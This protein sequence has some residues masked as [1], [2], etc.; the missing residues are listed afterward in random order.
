MPPK[1]SKTTHPAKPPPKN[2]SSLRLVLVESPSKC[3][4]IETYLGEGYRVLATYGHF[5]ELQSLRDIVISKD[6][7]N[8]E[9]KFQI[10]DR[11]E[12][13]IS[14]LQKAIT[15]SMEVILATDDDREGEA[16]AWHI[17]DHFH[18]PVENTK[19]IVFHEITEEAIQTAIQEPR[20]VNMNLVHAQFAR[21]ILDMYIGYKISP[22]LWTY[23][24]NNTK[25][26]LSAG[27]CQTPALKMIADNQ[28]HIHSLQNSIHHS[29]SGNFTNLNIPFKLNKYFTE[30]SEVLEFMESCKHFPFSLSRLE[31]TFSTHSAPTPL[32]TSRLQQQISNELHISP[33]ETMSI[34]QKL[35][36][37]G[38]ITYMRTDNKK[39]SNSFIS[40]V[41]KYMTHNMNES[42]LSEDINRLT[43]T[44][45]SAH[46]AIRPT[47]IQV[48]SLSQQRHEP[49]V[50]KVYRIIWETSV[51]SCL[52]S[53]TS[54]LQKFHLTAPNGHMFVCETE[55]P[56]YDGWKVIYSRK[57]KSKDEG[58]KNKYHHYLQNVADG[59]RVSCLKIESSIE[60]SS[61]KG[62][63]HY[64]E[65]NLIQRLEKEGIGR[66][67]TFAS[68]IDK[69]QR[70]DYA[71]KEDI[72]GTSF[73]ANTYRYNPTSGKI[74]SETITKIFGK[75]RNKLIIQNMGL[76]VN[77]FLYSHFLPLFDFSYTRETECVLD[78]ISEGVE[79]WVDVCVTQKAYIAGLIK[80]AKNSDIKKYEVPIDSE[81]SYMIAKYGPVIRKV[82][83]LTNEISW[84]RVI[85]EVDLNKLK[86]GGYSV[87]E[88]L[89][90]SD[91]GGGDA[92]NESD[93]IDHPEEIAESNEKET[94]DQDDNDI[95]EQMKSSSGYLYG[96]YDNHEIRV[97]NG[98]YGRYITWKG[99]N[100]SI[101]FFGT[102]D[103]R[104][105]TM[106]E[107]E[108]V[109]NK[110]K[111][112]FRKYYKK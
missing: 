64:T 9:L 22:M 91:A 109:I 98:K 111:K 80:I 112:V 3:H 77:D 108:K 84:L 50:C 53:S 4:K 14:T 49:K 47:N 79:N 56:I 107:M 35:Y 85:K 83:P 86:Q 39:Y 25:S 45:N 68:I 34:C 44:N 12:K 54:Y 7:K 18:L 90:K 104:N 26:P 72:E 29:I 99:E 16:I 110:E 13:H 60:C 42:Y 1:K 48:E 23:V 10:D 15:E 52:K 11:K 61:S 2:P 74:T 43:E 31:P 94:I 102:R 87:D 105:I 24:A 21:Q 33:K 97:K 73:T 69:I 96:T 32:N 82:D 37:E 62:A 51:S 81:H 20:T 8:I 70:R 106:E 5:R 92:V 41:C 27:R 100:K 78:R 28:S 40:M 17:C 59:T 65:A 103:I 66:P 6:K 57:N 63:L 93:S 19:R 75:E 67:S 89:L 101:K 36:E 88:L 46:E 76:I 38:L 71:N 95:K 58:N 55:Q 30:E